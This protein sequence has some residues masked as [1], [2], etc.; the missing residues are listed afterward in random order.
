MS[1][2]GIV[3]TSFALVEPLGALAREMLP[4][5]EVVNLVDDTLLADARERGVDERLTRRMAL[6]FQAA[7][8]AGADVILNACSSVGETVDAVQ[9]EIAAPIVKI[10]A[11]MADAAVAEGGRIAVL[12]TVSSTLG[13]TC[14]LLESRARA[15]GA[16]IELSPLLCDGAFDLLVA[17]R[18]EEHDALVEATALRTA[19]EH[20]RIVLA[21]ASMA[22]LVP[23]LEGRLGVPLLASPALAMRQI[24]G[25]LATTTP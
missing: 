4:G 24:A 17:G 1:R 2:M 23:R 18:R 10:D 15:A 25:M 22:R 16:S 13:P 8:L 14:R 3:H 6:L 5:T 12:A 7:A 19:R 20:D 9:G 11:A 21:Q